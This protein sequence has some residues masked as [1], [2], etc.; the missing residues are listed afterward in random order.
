M[1]TKY[2]HGP[3][4]DRVPELTHYRDEGC[5]VWHACLSCPLPRCVYDDPRQGRGAKTRMRDADIARLS[6][7]G[8]TANDLA[9]R[10][11][12]SRRQIFRILRQERGS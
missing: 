9:A 12:I 11:H 5:T 1:T 10:Y 7:E 2:G 3:V 4:M 8:W 6:G